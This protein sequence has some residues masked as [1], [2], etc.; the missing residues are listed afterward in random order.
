MQGFNNLDLS[1]KVLIFSAVILLIPII[2]GL[3]LPIVKPTI[4]RKSNIYLYSFS[5]GFILV[6]G[7]YGLIAQPMME[8]QEQLSGGHSHNHG[9][10]SHAH[11]YEQWEVILIMAGVAVAGVTLG[12]GGSFLARHIFIK[13]AGEVHGNHDDHNHGDHIFNIKEAQSAKSKLT[14]ITL[15][16]FHKLP[17]GI[18]LG[19]MIHGMSTNHS[20]ITIAAI[21]AFIIHTIPEMLTIYYRQIEMGLNKWKA[22]GYTLVI[23]L[24][25]V[26]L[27]FIGAYIGE[28]IQDVVWLMPMIF[29]ISGSILVFTSIIELIPE[30]I[31][32]NISHAKWHITMMLFVIGFMSALLI[33][34]IHV[35]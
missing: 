31:D 12:M 10:A 6:L 16:A 14:V 3:I 26:P 24:L 35:H 15:L 9:A 33:L 18:S 32:Q 27:M 2:L 5:A 13:K 25:L 21:V 4:K 29:V 28:G 23:Q 11:H 22:M 8:L 17:A 34:L 20:G 7:L 30:F 1:L 19:L